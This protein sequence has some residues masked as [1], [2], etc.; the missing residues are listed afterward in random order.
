MSRNLEIRVA[1]AHLKK[2]RIESAQL[3]EGDILPEM[4]F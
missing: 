4:F 3:H 2:L 1:A